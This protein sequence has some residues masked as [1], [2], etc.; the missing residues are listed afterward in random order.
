MIENGKTGRCCRDLV[1]ASSK[2]GWELVSSADSIWACCAAWLWS[3][4]TV[5]NVNSSTGGMNNK[6]ARRKI[7]GR[8]A[9]RDGCV[10][11]GKVTLLSAGRGNCAAERTRWRKRARASIRWRKIK[12]KC[13]RLKR[14]GLSR[15]I[16]VDRP[17]FCCKN[18][19]ML[20]L[21]P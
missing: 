9:K 10:G 12:E 2:A 20:S 16:V 6:A 8:C 7:R 19:K 4:R 5:S 3:K 13:V 18:L 21:I 1:E 17:A 15:V 11:A 14:F